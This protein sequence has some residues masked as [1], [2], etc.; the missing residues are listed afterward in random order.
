MHQESLNTLLSSPFKGPSTEADNG[1]RSQKEGLGEEGRL[2]HTKGGSMEIPSASVEGEE[3]T[4]MSV[5]AEFLRMKG[6]Y[7]EDVEVE[8]QEA[9]PK[10]Q[11]GIRVRV[12][13]GEVWAGAALLV[14]LLLERVW[15]SAL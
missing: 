1:T 14:L 10:S 4:A 8:E 12:M 3:E 15:L 13:G 2:S 7:H 11:P 6:L 5:D 9:K